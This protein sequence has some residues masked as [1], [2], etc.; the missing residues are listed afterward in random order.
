MS[1]KCNHAFFRQ[2]EEEC[3]QSTIGSDSLPMDCD[4][5][6]AEAEAEGQQGE[7]D[8]DME[9]DADADED[10]DTDEEVDDEDTDE[11]VED[12][13]FSYTPYDYRIDALSD[14]EV[15]VADWLSS[16]TTFVYET[17]DSSAL[18]QSEEELVILIKENN[19]SPPKLYDDIM[20][21][22]TRASERGYPFGKSPKKKTKAC[23]RTIIKA[24][25]K[26][27]GGP[28]QETQFRLDGYQHPIRVYRNSFIGHMQR[29]LLDPEYMAGSI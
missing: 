23:L 25:D 16:H 29:L 21:W 5:S 13:Q 26:F 18:D 10:T 14:D 9:T 28:P 7:N 20:A 4:V 6:E 1:C 19:C 3:S 24:Y 15:L 27:V 8:T 11:E 2:Y 12:E 17:M 22:V